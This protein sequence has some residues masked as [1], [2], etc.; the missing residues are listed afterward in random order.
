MTRARTFEGVTPAVL[1]RIRQ[2]GRSYGVRFTP[3]EGPAG[4]A[5][6]RTP[7][8]ECIISYAHDAGAARL[9]LVIRRKA[10][11][12]PSAVLWRQLDEI[13]DACRRQDRRQQS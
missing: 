10:A 4:E 9:T 1:G 5:V 7:M 8:G 2:V 3:E 13:I 12:L 6:G 11:L